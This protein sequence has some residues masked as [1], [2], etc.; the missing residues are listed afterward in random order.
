M[1]PYGRQDTNLDDIEAVKSVLNSDW[2]TS[3]PTIPQFEEAIAKR[4][5]ANW[6]VAVS[7]ATAALHIAC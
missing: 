6:A 4:C 1:I 5:A 2:L 7:N 3:G